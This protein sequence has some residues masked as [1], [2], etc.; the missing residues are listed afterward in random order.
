VELLRVTQLSPQGFHD[1][2]D[3]PIGD[4]IRR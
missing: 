1:Q 4:G 2:T 3:E